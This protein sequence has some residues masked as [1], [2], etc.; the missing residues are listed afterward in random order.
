MSNELFCKLKGE[1]LFD[2]GSMSDEEISMLVD[3]IIQNF[4]PHIPWG[5]LSSNETDDVCELMMKVAAHF[6]QLGKKICWES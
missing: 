1:F 5:D 3:E 4:Y 6:Y 2:Q